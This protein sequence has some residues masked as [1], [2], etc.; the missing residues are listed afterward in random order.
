MN[1]KENSNL[2]WKTK[3][4]VEIQKSLCGSIKTDN[5]IESTCFHLKSSPFHVF[6]SNFS[7]G[8]VFCDDNDSTLIPESTRPGG[9]PS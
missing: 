8:H 6:S 7:R 4:A 1:F 5:L 3:V 9:F 2:G